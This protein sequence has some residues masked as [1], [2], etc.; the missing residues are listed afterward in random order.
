MVASTVV[1][2]SMLNKVRQARCQTFAGSFYRL[3]NGCGIL[4]AVFHQDRDHQYID[5]KSLVSLQELYPKI[6]VVTDLEEVL[7]AKRKAPGQPLVLYKKSSRESEGTRV[8]I[9]LPRRKPPIG[10]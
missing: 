10:F 8:T 7:L 1:T 3:E 6:R 9:G 4:Q 5:S 2:K